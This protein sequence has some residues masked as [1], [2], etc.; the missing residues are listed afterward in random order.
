MALS[1]AFVFQTALHPIQNS[2]AGLGG[3]DTAAR[4]ED[5]ERIDAARTATRSTAK[6]KADRP[7][8]RHD[9]PSWHRTHAALMWPGESAVTSAEVTAR[10][11]LTP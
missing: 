6:R 4:N 5:L 2:R 7:L 9:P 10:Y 1:L 3:S 8:H 11:R